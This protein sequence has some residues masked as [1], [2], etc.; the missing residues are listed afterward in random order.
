M[1]VLVYED[2]HDEDRAI[3]VPIEP[4]DP[5]AEA[6]RSGLEIGAE[7]LFI[8]PD[9][10]DRPHVPDIYPDPYAAYASASTNARGLPCTRSGAATRLSSTPRRW[11]ETPGA[12]LRRH[13]VVS[14][15]ADAGS[16][17]WNSRRKS[18]T[19]GA[20]LKP[21]DVHL[22]NPHPD[23]LAEIAVEYPYYRIAMRH[24]AQTAG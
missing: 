12:D 14:L 22:I 21:Y 13:S 6:V 9:V 17:P 1:T 5:F 3:Y 10:I 20:Y 2:G 24:F 15:N 16:T 18:P 19:R 7:V 11:P 23:C 8:E 4:A